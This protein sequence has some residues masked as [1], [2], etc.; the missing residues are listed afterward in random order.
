M[1]E[2]AVKNDFRSITKAEGIEE[3]IK[4]VKQ[5]IVAKK[6]RSFY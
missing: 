4:Q 3:Y 5:F 6:D 1:F 2:L